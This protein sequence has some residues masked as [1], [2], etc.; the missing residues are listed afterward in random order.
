MCLPNA[1]LPP[2]KRKLALAAN[3]N[4]QKALCSVWPSTE[5]QS[6]TVC[7]HSPDNGCAFNKAEVA[8]LSSA[9][10]YPEI[11]TEFAK[12]LAIEMASSVRI[13]DW[14]TVETILIRLLRT[15]LKPGDLTKLAP[16]QLGP[17]IFAIEQR[18][19]SP[20]NNLSGRLATVL[21]SLW[22]S[23]L[24][25]LKAAHRHRKRPRCEL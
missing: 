7:I 25:R 5:R 12:G 11:S 17:L 10:R 23:H 21:V 18:P 8:R 9:E 19:V 20:E 2:R 4:F 6:G 16:T 22:S 14:T 13:R 24:L 1:A 15:E 3:G